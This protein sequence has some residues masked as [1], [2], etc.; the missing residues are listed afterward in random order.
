MAATSESKKRMIPA[1]PPLDWAGVLAALPEPG[2]V[3]LPGFLP[4]SLIT[5]LRDELRVLD[6]AGQFHAAGIGR[7]ASQQVQRQIRGDRIAWLAT[8]AGMPAA[9]EYLVI[10]DDL[11]QTLNR[12][13]FLGLA[14]YEAHYACYEPGSFYRRHV[15]KHGSDAEGAGRGQRVIS[16]VCYVNEPGWPEDTGGE[17][18]LYPEDV[19]RALKVTPEAGTLVVFRSDNLAHE[20]LPAQLQRLSIAGW[21]RTRD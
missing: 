14:E 19:R 3:V 2:Y 5:A 17:L 15:D 10:M 16:T 11:R 18:V 8:A 4:A 13:Y 12:E 1:L 21:M 9:S 6:A 7:G 20:V